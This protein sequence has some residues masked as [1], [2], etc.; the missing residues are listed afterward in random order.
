MLRDSAAGAYL[1]VLESMAQEVETAIEA[2]S[3]N[4]LL[5]LEESVRKQEILCGTMAA[6]AGRLRHQN[7]IQVSKE[8]QRLH[9]DLEDVRLSDFRRKGS[10]SANSSEPSLKRMQSAEE[11]L[12]SLNQQYL[13]LLHHSGRSIELLSSLCRSYQG[14]FHAQSN[15]GQ[16]DCTGLNKEAR[17][18]GFRHQTW[19]CEV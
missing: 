17:I 19:S 11:R 10:S 8:H 6:A 4:R 5:D 12:R 13:A 18:A 3:G 14:R 2:I 9:S 16:L 15:V 1:Q 7:H